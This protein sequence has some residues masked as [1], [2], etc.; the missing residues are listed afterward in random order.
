MAESALRLAKHT[1]N[2]AIF[3]G[4]ASRTRGIS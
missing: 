4:H 3:R 2:A 1:R